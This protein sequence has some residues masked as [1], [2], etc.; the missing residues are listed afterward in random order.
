MSNILIKDYLGVKYMGKFM[1]KKKII[2]LPLIVLFLLVSFSSSM[3]AEEDTIEDVE[4]K[5]MDISEEE[6]IILEEL[7]IIAQDIEEL[8]RQRN[9]IAQEIEAMK[10]DIENLEELIQRETLNYEEKLNI[11]EQFLV[12][13][14]RMGPS[15]FIDIILSADSITNL[16]ERINILR[17]LAKNSAELLK[18]IE[19]I[20]DK[21]VAEKENLNEKLAAL[22]KRE[23]EL[24]ETI[25][26]EEEKKA[27]LEE[28]LASLEEDREYFQERLN[29]MMAMIDE[30]AELLKFLSQEFVNIIESENLPEDAVEYLIS[31]DGII[32][33]ISQDVFNDVISKH[34][35][36]PETLFRFYPERVEMEIGEKNLLLVGTFVIIDGHLIEF[37]VK[38]GV[39]YDMVLTKE[40]IDEFFREGNLSLDL[41][42]ILGNNSIKKILIIEEHVQMLI[43]LNI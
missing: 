12:S 33:K 19:E 3:K 15:S 11:L 1:G 39:F 4:E 36:I 16:L 14:Q 9:R 8:E 26:K 10:V 21:L 7:F 5:L 35:N 42:S 24:K 29:A 40:T 23:E 37:Q 31:R 20:R 43:E 17:D 18:S 22:S 25:L 34:P 32:G 30:L 13:Y 6:R 28:R 2:V 38:E 41:K 27:Q